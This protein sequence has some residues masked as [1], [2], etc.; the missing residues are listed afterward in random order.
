VFERNEVEQI[1]RP[2]HCSRPVAEPLVDHPAAIGAG[3]LRP[4][5]FVGGYEARSQQDRDH[6]GGFSN[7]CGEE[8]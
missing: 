5:G 7:E 8:L 3:W 4:A 6:A 1:A 2:L